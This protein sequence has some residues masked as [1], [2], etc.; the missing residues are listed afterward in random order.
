MP[1]NTILCV[2]D[3]RSDLAVSQ[4]LFASRSYRVIT[5][6]TDGGALTA[7]KAVPTICAAVLAMPVEPERQSAIASE[8]EA[9]RPGVLKL[10]IGDALPIPDLQ[11]FYV[12][13]VTALVEELQLIV[14][15]IRA[16]SCRTGA[17]LESSRTLRAESRR[18]RREMGILLHKAT[19]KANRH[20]AS[21]ATYHNTLKKL[22]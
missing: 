21:D 8:M 19:E 2:E 6:T 20:H 22:A 10:A 11:L 3:R 18:L 15:A 4:R 5:A 17:L 16:E 1:T 7:L 9:I 12:E 14:A 13:T